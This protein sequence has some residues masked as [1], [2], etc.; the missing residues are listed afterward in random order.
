MGDTVERLRGRAGQA[1]RLRR[2]KRTNGLCELCR[3]AGL[4]RQADVVDHIQ[5]LALGGSDEDSN[6][7]NL[8]HD[9]HREVTVE[10]FGQ[11]AAQ[12]RRG[13]ARS[14]R[15]TSPDHAWNRTPAAPLAA[16]PA[17]T[18]ARRPTPVGGAGGRK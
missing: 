16:P 2:L 18:P 13:V 7:R 3:N 4:T 11:Q 8:C 9:H 12:G 1:Q 17:P 5:P 15:P 6:T 14:G 10:Q